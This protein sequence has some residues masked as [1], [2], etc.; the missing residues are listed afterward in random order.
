MAQN[1]VF[2][3]IKMVIKYK[4]RTFAKFLRIVRL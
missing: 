2:C 3:V 1:D 4:L